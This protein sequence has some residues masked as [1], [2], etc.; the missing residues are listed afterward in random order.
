MTK[1]NGVDE[2]I[3][4]RVCINCF[5]LRLDFA[6]N[7]SSPSKVDVPIPTGIV[8]RRSNAINK[9]GVTLP[10]DALMIN[11][12]DLYEKLQQPLYEE[13]YR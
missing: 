11:D 7:N 3:E 2:E 5:G 12:I 8:K 1:I 4:S 9:A 13:S 10:I 6:P